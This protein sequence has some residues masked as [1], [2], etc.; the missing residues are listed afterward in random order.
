MVEEQVGEFKMKL[1]KTY[2]G[3]VED[4]NDPKKLGRVKVRVINVYDEMPIEDIPWA[5]PWKDLNGNYFNP[6]EKGK[7][8]VTVFDQDNKKNPEYI[9]SEHYNANLESKLSK[10]SDD[11]YISMKSLMFD[12]KTQIYV[13]ESEGLM[14]DYKYNNIN[15][16]DKN[17]DLNLK[18]NNSS[19]NIGDATATQQ[20]ILG[21]HFMDWLESF[22]DNLST[23]GLFTSSGPAMPNPALMK[24]LLEF[25]SM[26]DLKYLSHH[27]NVVDNNKIKT[28][29][30]QKRED[31][32]QYGDKWTST[33]QNNTITEKKVE[34]FTPDEGPKTE[35]D[36][37]VNEPITTNN[38][39]GT[40]STTQEVGVNQNL[41]TV[42]TKK[43]DPLIENLIKFLKSKN[44]NVYTEQY[45]LNIVAMNTKNDNLPTDKFDDILYVFYMNAEGK[46]EIKD[47][48]IST[49]VGM[50]N[51]TDFAGIKLL[52]FGQY[53]DM[54]DFTNYTSD[55]GKI[56]CLSFNGL[57]N[58]NPSHSSYIYFG[59]KFESIINIKP[60][61]ISGDYD[62]VPNVSYADQMFKSLNR[63]NEFMKLCESQIK[64]KSKLTYTLCRKIDFDNF[65]NQ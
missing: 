39:T 56:K 54:V 61:N 38:I 64:V 20:M 37:V 22:L 48:E 17:I 43:I 58:F 31:N 7:I 18:D 53:C 2:I 55:L 46:W 35:P 11:D 44:Y 13:N 10:L 6:P 9:Y 42:E 27:V 25:K 52:A 41:I 5:S 49:V 33:K 26:K 29:S 23:G 14:I 32:A 15:L 57:T 24:L 4:N 12:H 50:K 40:P 36:T 59:N 45:V 60:A 62:F 47:Y 63:F 28:V 1:N 30:G 16:K 19:L 65:T 21:N 51:R 34:D 8:V 3:I